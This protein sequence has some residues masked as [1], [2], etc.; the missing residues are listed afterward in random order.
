MCES[1]TRALPTHPCGTTVCVFDPEYFA[2]KAERD[3]AWKELQEIREAINANTEESTVDE[4]RR[5]IVDRDALVVQM[6]EL[7]KLHSDLTNADM[8]L[9]DGEHSGYLITSE[10]IDDMEHYLSEPILCLSA[11]DAEVAANAVEKFVK[12]WRSDDNEN[13]IGYSKQYAAKLRAKA[14]GL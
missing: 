9:D 2:L 13:F 7:N 5:V 11:H 14:G 3:N 12:D 4:V 10:Q 8:V 1:K 6:L